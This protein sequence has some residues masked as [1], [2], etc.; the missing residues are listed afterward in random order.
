[1]LWAHARTRFAQA[2]AELGMSDRTGG[3]SSPNYAYRERPEQY[4][5]DEEVV[6]DGE[7]AGMLKAREGGS[8]G[9]RLD[10]EE[11]RR[12][13]QDLAL[14][15]NL[16]VRAINL[17]KVV[18]SMLDQP[19]PVHYPVLDDEPATPSSSPKRSRRKDHPHTLPNGVRLR[20][21]LGAVVNDLF[22]RQ[23]PISPYRH[24]HHPPPII[25]STNSDQ[26][27][28][29]SFSPSTSPVLQN[30]S[31]NPSVGPNAVSSSCCDKMPPPSLTLLSSVSF[32]A[33]KRPFSHIVRPPSQPLL[34]LP[35]HPNVITL[36]SRARSLYLEGA[37]HST[38]N[39]SLGLRCQRHLHAGCEICVEARQTF[40]A[41]GGI[42][43]ARGSI[44]FGNN[45]SSRAS[46]LSSAKNGWGNVGGVTGCH[47]GGGIGSGLAQ[48]DINGSALRRK[49]KYV[50]AAD[51]E[52]AGDACSSGNPRLVELI[53]RFLRLSALVA[54]ELG[55]ELGEEIYGVL[56]PEL[57]ETRTADEASIPTPCSPSTMSPKRSHVSDV[58]PAPLSPSLEWYMLLGGLLTRAALEGYLTGGW[59]G[60]DTAECLLSIG[61]GFNDNVEVSEEEDLG[62]SA[63]EWF[64]PDDLPGLKG[65]TRI[66]FPSLRRASGGAPL[67]PDNPEVLYHVE[68]EARIRRFFDIPQQ[69][70]DLATHME[71][72][73]WHYPA[74]PIERAALRF[75]EAVAKWRGKPELETYEKKP[76]GSTSHGL[77]KLAM[78]SGLRPPQRPSIEKYFVVPQSVTTGRNKRRQSF[79]DGDRSFKRQ[80]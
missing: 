49:S 17:E 72:L 34:T 29:D 36:G 3:P 59:R 61:R 69:T 12:Q 77:V 24:H 28:S 22:A 2:R 63:F 7:D 35:L 41:P 4:E 16:R 18:T 23:A 75:C 74:E 11:E 19:P 15:R 56:Q 9:T 14:S 44:N 70:P 67:R 79:D 53:P 38:A 30:V 39:A 52:H 6:S 60:A 62:D 50:V 27:S 58:D 47:D 73:A 68:M 42:G 8:G 25:I 10:D 33:S 45:S 1:M 21:A 43:R 51:G 32:P 13:R 37:D 5:E 54:V 40:K 55:R 31:P 65:S 76:K 64:D 48:P 46:H 80:Q 57:V 71:D 78:E 26:G 66:L 20:L